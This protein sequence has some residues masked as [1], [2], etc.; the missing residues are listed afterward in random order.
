MFNDVAE[1][2]GTS[3]VERNV[4]NRTS[5]AFVGGEVLLICRPL[6][7]VLLVWRY[8]LKSWRPWL[9]ALS[10]DLAGMY[11]V[12]SSTSSSQI[13]LGLT[14]VANT[15]QVSPIPLSSTEA[16]EVTFPTLLWLST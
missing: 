8:G 3:S 5:R 2:S 12:S 1:N 9:A 14:G 7:Y 6:L 4:E 10:I 15:Q 16:L 11:L 13:R